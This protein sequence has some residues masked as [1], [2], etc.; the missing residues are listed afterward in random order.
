MCLVLELDNGKVVSIAN[1][2]NHRQIDRITE[3]SSTVL[4]HDNIFLDKIRFDVDIIS[5]T[6][7]RKILQFRSKLV[8]ELCAT[9][10]T[11]KIQKILRTLNDH[12]SKTKDHQIDF[13]FVSEHSATAWTKK[14]DGSFSGGGGGK[15]GLHVVD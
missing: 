12:I 2:Q 13:S 15:E 11:E 4:V 14:R 10:R 3:P 9:F 5:K 7:N 1:E 6:I 8:S